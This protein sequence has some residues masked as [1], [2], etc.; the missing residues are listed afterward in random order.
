VLESLVTLEQAKILNSLQEPPEVI[1]KKLNLSMEAVETHFREM[2]GKG[3]LYPGRSGWHLTRS[4]AALHD[5]APSSNAKYDNDDFLDLAFAKADETV[6][7]QIAEVAE[8]RAPAIRQGMRVIPR[9]KAV[10]DIEG[11]LPYEDVREI[12]KGVEPIVLLPCACKKIDRNRPCRDTVPLE[13]CIT[14][15]KS[16]QYNLNRGT[17]K[18]LTYDEVMALLDEFDKY[19]LVHLVGNY[20]AMPA[21]VCNCHNCCCG[22]FYRNTRARKQINQFSIAKSRFIAIVETEKCTGCKTCT[23]RC[24]VGAVAMKKQPSGK[25]ISS[26]SEDECIGCGLCV[27]SCPANARRLKT[28]RPPEYIPRR[29]SLNADP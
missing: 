1:A 3:L 10:K 27:I 14:I 7:R 6:K 21:L 15:G 25:D 26:T 18:K 2:F 9:W 23:L 8:G 24:P 5:S 11:V 12:F 28:I 22:S 16:A 4:W 29:D 19:Q 13:S 17:G 20:G